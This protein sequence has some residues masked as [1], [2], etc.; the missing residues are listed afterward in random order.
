MAAYLGRKC[1]DLAQ[2]GSIRTPRSCR[3]APPNPRQH[4]GRARRR[5]G[6]RPPR[7]QCEELCACRLLANDRVEAVVRCGVDLAPLPERSQA[8]RLHEP[9]F[10]IVAAPAA[11]RGL[12]LELIGGPEQKPGRRSSRRTTW[13]PVRGCRSL[14]ET[15]GPRHAGPVLANRRVAPA[16]PSTQPLS[17]ADVASRRGEGRGATRRPGPIFSRDC[18]SPVVRGVQ[19]LASS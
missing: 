5:L 10:W 13:L 3:R 17:V 12:L 19:L 15:P 6:A 18:V 1:T 14:G 4:K 16:L 11:T 7:R 2:R 8:P 9:R